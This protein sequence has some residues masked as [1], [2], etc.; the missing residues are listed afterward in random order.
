MNIL[1]G[2][3]IALPTGHRSPRGTFHVRFAVAVGKRLTV[4]VFRQ[5]M[6]QL[7]QGVEDIWRGIANH[8]QWAIALHS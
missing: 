7:F 1:K 6:N 8:S 3:R 4:N 5:R 2:D